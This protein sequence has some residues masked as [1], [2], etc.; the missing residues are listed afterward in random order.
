MTSL[1]AIGLT[2]SLLAGQPFEASYALLECPS[3]PG[4]CRLDGSGRWAPWWDGPD[5]ADLVDYQVGEKGHVVVLLR[6][7]QT[8][9][10]L[11]VLEPSGRVL[12]RRYLGA[13]RSLRALV[14]WLPGGGAILCNDT[15]REASCDVVIG[16]EPTLN[17]PDPPRPGCLFPRLSV[18][19]LE[20][21]LC[22]EGVVETRD[23][24]GRWN[25]RTLTLPN[26][27]VR[28]F[29]VLPSG[30]MFVVDRSTMYRFA[31]GSSE[32][33]VVDRV[34]W[35]GSSRGSFFTVTCTSADGTSALGPCTVHREAGDDGA[36][37]S[38]DLALVP[39]EIQETT[40]GSVMVELRK[41][42]DRSVVEL[43]RGSPGARL[44]WSDPSN[45]GASL[46]PSLPPA[47]PR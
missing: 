14:G 46:S 6:S 19:G 44:I 8:E 16:V 3:S 11:L 21:C 15:H 10:E 7:H 34:C 20:S 9:G 5:A 32:P 18:P 36:R 24:E 17:P 27:S 4:L 30:E 41:D 13:A 26:R 22:D 33:S 38:W 40:T 23:S 28:D 1:A 12:L 37:D 42:G 31:R 25:A 45:R 47:A 39:V 29:Q 35:V 2:V 43:V